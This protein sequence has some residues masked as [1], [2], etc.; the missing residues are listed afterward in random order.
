M[1]SLYWY[2]GLAVIGF[3]ITAYAIYTK[4][5]NYKISTLVVFCLFATSITWIGEFTVLGIFD[6]YA[7]KPG[8]STDPWAENLAGHL[9]LNASMFP[10]AAILMVTNSLGYLG[11]SLIVTVFILAEYLFEELGIYEHHWWKY[12]MSV[13]N[14]VLFLVIVKKWFAKVKHARRTLSRVI[15]FY[16]VGFV[17]IHTPIPLLFLSGKQY[18]SLGL[19]ENMV[20]NTCRASI[21]FIFAYHLLE[22]S[23]FVLF[24]CILDKWYWKIV[25]YVI[26]VL[27]QSIFAKMNILVFLNG[28]KL[29]YSI[30][31]YCICLTVFILIEKYTLRPD[32]QN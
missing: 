16:F 4:R 3:G 32:E 25:P 29:I 21:I 9:F 12:Y 2:A 7:Y 13:I 31:I 5:H 30:I 8:I 19:I 14:T 24:I 11:V 10:A 23:I 6:S 27:V 26:A 18:Y 20:G 28:W 15:T 1:T 22:L 17:I